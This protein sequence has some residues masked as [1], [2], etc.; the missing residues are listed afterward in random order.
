[1]PDY[2][3]Q[4]PR[5]EG[6]VYVKLVVWKNGEIRN[7]EILKGLAGCEPCNEEALRLVKIMPNWEPAL[8]KGTA[9]NFMAI[10]PITFKSPENVKEVV[11]G[12]QFQGGSPAQEKYIKDNLKYPARAL[13]EKIE[14]KVFLTIHVDAQG[15]VTDVK[16]D[17]GIANCPECD[18][19]AIRLAK[20]IPILY[21]RKK[22]TKPEKSQMPFTVEFKL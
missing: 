3:V 7:I 2:L 20:E 8:Q 17:K 9:V 16:M 14:G 4:N 10:C 15:K 22:N 6:T 5:I 19:E 21:P 18:A 12:A 1:M 13:S 11:V